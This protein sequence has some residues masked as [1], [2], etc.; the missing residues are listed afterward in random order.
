MAACLLLL[1]CS[2][3]A[4]RMGARDRNADPWANEAKDF[5]RKR[6]V[7]REVSHLPPVSVLSWVLRRDNLPRL[8]LD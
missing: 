6:L 2:I 4:P 8:L 1:L 5:L 7:G 3:R